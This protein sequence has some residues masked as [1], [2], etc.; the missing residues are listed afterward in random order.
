[1]A[2]IRLK[3][4]RNKTCFFKYRKTFIDLLN[5][6]NHKQNYKIYIATKL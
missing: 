4:V 6:Y 1:M 2:Q 3:N 5:H